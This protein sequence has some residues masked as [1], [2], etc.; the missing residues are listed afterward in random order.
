M[1]PNTLFL[2]GYINL[3][4]NKQNILAKDYLVE[5]ELTKLSFLMKAH[6]LNI[7]KKKFSTT[8]LRV[9][10]INDKLQLKN[11]RRNIQRNFY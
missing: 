11:N 6:Y 7:F 1:G 8:N 3:K 10:H 2:N 5:A 4:A 9:Y